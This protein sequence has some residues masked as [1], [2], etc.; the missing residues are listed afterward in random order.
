MKTTYSDVKYTLKK[1][2]SL[3]NVGEMDNWGYT[4]V[5]TKRVDTSMKNLFI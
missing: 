4:L 2:G 1:K 5:S 3:L